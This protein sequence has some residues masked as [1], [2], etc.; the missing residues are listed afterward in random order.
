MQSALNLCA[1]LSKAAATSARN[2]ERLAEY[3]QTAG[4]GT[5]GTV[6]GRFDTLAQECG[7]RESSDITI[8]C[9]TDFANACSDGVIAYT[10]PSDNKMTM[11]KLFWTYD[12][13]N[14]DAAGCHGQ[15]R[16]TTILHEFTHADAVFNTP[17]DDNGYGFDAL[18][19]L[20]PTEA[21]NNADTYAQYANG[22]SQSC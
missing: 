3:F 7:A 10:L 5:A 2:G 4:N 12:A 16:A 9:Q 17:T 1:S 18:Q 8:Y 6:G 13:P 19:G 15:D 14:P 11:C 20:S 21:L 22:I